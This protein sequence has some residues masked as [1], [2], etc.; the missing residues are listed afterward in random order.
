ME[1]VHF[2][3]LGLTVPWLFIP[4]LW[5]YFIPH[6]ICDNNS[7]IEQHDIFSFSKASPIETEVYPHLSILIKYLPIKVKYTIRLLFNPHNIF[8][9]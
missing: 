7:V 4:Q 1:G 2:L 9:G 6:F 8:P 3:V 5:Y